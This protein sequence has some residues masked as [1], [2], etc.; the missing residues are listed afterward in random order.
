MKVDKRHMI[1]EKIAELTNNGLEAKEMLSFLPVKLTKTDLIEVIKDLQAKP[2]PKFYVTL[3]SDA[4]EAG[5]TYGP[6]TNEEDAILDAA[7]TIEDF[8][9]EQDFLLVQE[10]KGG[11]DK[12]AYVDSYVKYFEY[13]T[14][15]EIKQIAQVEPEDLPL[16]ISK[17]KE[18]ESRAY[19]EALLKRA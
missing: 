15:K 16:L 1:C 3:I 6:Y 17:L 7:S 18:E 12:D 9:A 19:L 14:W 11:Q 8:D 10:M 2:E 5:G 13:D 4:V